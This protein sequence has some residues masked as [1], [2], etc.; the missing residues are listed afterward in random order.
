MPVTAT[1]A[2]AAPTTVPATATRAPAAPVTVPV[3]TL[4]TN[5]TAPGQQHNIT[6]ECF[7]LASDNK[8]H[9]FQTEQVAEDT[10]ISQ[11]TKP[12]EMEQNFKSEEK[13]IEHVDKESMAVKS[14]KSGTRTVLTT[15]TVQEK[16][17][18]TLYPPAL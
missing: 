12:E 15:N 17:Q 11:N 16:D 9:S 7:T 1:K 18:Q 8:K 6:S 14:P 2:P 3:T 4:P 13:P 10:H 5:L